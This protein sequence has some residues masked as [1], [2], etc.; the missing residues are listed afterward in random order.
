MIRNS[1]TTLDPGIDVAPGV[2]VVPLFKISHHN[3][4]TFLHH[5][6]HCGHF[7]FFFLQN[8]LKINKRSP[9]FI[10]ESRVVVCTFNK[11]LRAC[12]KFRNRK[13]FRENLSEKYVI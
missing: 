5:S 8:D 3:F 6:R 10:P 1:L 11:D 12:K 2:T 4:N 7:N 9:M 13:K